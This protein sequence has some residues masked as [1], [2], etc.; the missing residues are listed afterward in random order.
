VRDLLTDP[1]DAPIAAAILSLARDIGLAV[2]AE[3]VETEAQRVWLTERGCQ[4]FQGYLFG[5][6]GPIDALPGLKIRLGNPSAPVRQG[7]PETWA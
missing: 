3:G 5:R 2:I 1:C 6:P 7:P 4:A